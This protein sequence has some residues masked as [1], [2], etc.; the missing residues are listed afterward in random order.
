MRKIRT[1]LVPL[2]ISAC[3][4]P[5]SSDTPDTTG[6]Q[7]NAECGDSQL[8]IAEVCRTTCTT[9][10]DCAVNEACSAGV[11]LLEQGESCSDTDPCS[12]GFT[13]VSGA[14]QPL[15]EVGSACTFP[16][17]CRSGECG[18]G[19]IC[20]D[21]N[22]RNPCE[23]CLASETGLADGACGFAMAGLNPDGRCGS[24]ASCDSAG[25]CV[26]F[27][28][29]DFEILNAAIDGCEP[30][31]RVQIV[32]ASADPEIAELDIY[33]GDTLLQDDLNF[34]SATEVIKVPLRQGLV[35]ARGDSTD[36]SAPLVSD[37][38][39]QAGRFLA[40]IRGLVGTDF[41]TT[42][43]NTAL[44]LDLVPVKD[45]SDSAADAEILFYHAVT[46]AAALSVGYQ[47]TPDVAP[48]TPLLSNV[49]YGSASAYTSV[50]AGTTPY[51]VYLEADGTRVGSVQTSSGDLVP[52]AT[53]LTAGNAIALIA[54]GFRNP[55]NNGFGL[56]DPEAANF[57]VLAVFSDGTIT[58]RESRLFMLRYPRRQPWTYTSRRSAKLL[59]ARSC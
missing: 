15:F 8:C 42:V 50:P 34:A 48:P 55:R 18:A 45:V 36:P 53:G 59:L 24:L 26:P 22:C 28:D 30:A 14:C 23:S 21:R 57:Q 19:G 47:D 17:E 29:G 4:A 38:P 41:D 54:T 37:I 25:A 46:D 1:L 16:E 12:T 2:C 32:H 9:V 35:I 52:A 43:N 56:F 13:C 44:T 10:S 27:C 6:C 58:P 40:V 20:C 51:D 3:F 5:R 33:A 11:C 39:T 7:S 31:Y 49:A